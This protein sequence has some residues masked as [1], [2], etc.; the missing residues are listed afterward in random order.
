MVEYARRRHVRVLP[1]IE[2]PGHAQ[3]AIAAYPELGIGGPVEVARHWG[4]FNYDV[5]NPFEATF[6]FLENVFDE[7]TDLFPGEFIHV[8]GDEVLKQAWKESPRPRPA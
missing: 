5:F 7:V 6:E 4:I 8:G 1:E 3:A 2:M